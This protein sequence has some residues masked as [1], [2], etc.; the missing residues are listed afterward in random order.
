MNHRVLLIGCGRIAQR[1]AQLLGTKQIQGATLCG[2][3]DVIPT[4]ANTLSLQYRIPYYIEMHDA[5]QRGRPTIITVCTESGHH[6]RDV[7]ELARYGIPII[8]E[9]PIALTLPDAHRM[10]QACATHGTRLF[11]VKQNR[12]N[13]PVQKLREAYE[14]GRFGKLISAAIRVRW[15]RHQQYY[16]DWHGLWAM[17]GGALANQAIHHVDLLWWFMGDVASVFAYKATQLVDVEVEDSIVGA[18][19]FANGALGTLEVT[20]ATRPRDTEGSLTI[21]GE[22]GMVEI[23]GFAV[24]EITTWQFE[25]TQPIDATIGEYSVNPPDVYGFGHQQYYEH[26][27]DCINNHRAQLVDG[28]E[29]TKSLEIVTALYESCETGR[30]ICLGYPNA[31]LGKG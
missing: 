14:L 5:V 7:V 17:A 11:V 25:D 18:L 3:C 21:M 20:T 12:F 16:D 6:C 10:I 15:C 19:R 4:K 2:V 23:G 27:L 24:N 31:R 9:K 28:I 30:E 8:V 26:V 22:H 13:V 1:H 29:A